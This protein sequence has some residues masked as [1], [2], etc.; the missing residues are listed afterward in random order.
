MKN[1]EKFV[2]E[3]VEIATCGNI[4]AVDKNGKIM[5]CNP[6]ACIR[7]IGGEVTDCAKLIKQWAEAEYVEPK[8]FTEEEKALIRM[9]DK[10]QWVARDKS[11]ALFGF[12]VKP[13]KG[14]T[15]WG[16]NVES[17]FVIMTYLCSL[18]FSAI[19]WEDDEPTSREEI[20]R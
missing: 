3:I 17:G 2:K 8:M 6:D 13:E 15:Q 5:D 4:I 1:K 20:L 14:I 12:P 9:L 18:K 11:G 16:L 19:K 7:C 10:V